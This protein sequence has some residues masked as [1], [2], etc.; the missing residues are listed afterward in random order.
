MAGARHGISE[1]ARHGMGAA[2]HVCISLK[3][4]K[5]ATRHSGVIQTSNQQFDVQLSTEN[6][7]AFLKCTGDLYLKEWIFNAY[8]S[9]KLQIKVLF[10]S[11]RN[12]K[13]CPL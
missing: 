13:P 4:V 7:T 5:Q 9:Y 11:Y 2:W 12:H 1:L 6:Q 8:L 10:V 3:R